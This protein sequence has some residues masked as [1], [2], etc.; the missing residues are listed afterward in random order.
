MPLVRKKEKKK[1]LKNWLS[2]RKVPYAMHF[3]FATP[4]LFPTFLPLPSDLWLIWPKGDFNKRLREWE[5]NRRRAF[6]PGSQCTA[7]CQSHRLPLS[8]Y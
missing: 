8:L 1:P 3:P 7:S 5:E 6:I 4:G 2:L